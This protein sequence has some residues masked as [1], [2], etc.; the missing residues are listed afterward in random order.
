LAPVSYS[1]TGKPAATAA[2]ALYDR[3][4]TAMP[5]PVIHRRRA[6]IAPLVRPS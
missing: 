3:V 1:T 5:P 4:E 6:L 2:A